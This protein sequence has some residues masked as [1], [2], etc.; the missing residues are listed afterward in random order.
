M[1]TTAI[2]AL[3]ALT[4]LGPSANAA[5]VL[6]MSDLETSLPPEFSG[7]GAIEDVQSF[8]LVTFGTKF[9]R[10]DAAGNPAAATILTVTNLA[11]HTTLSLS[12][13]LAVIDSWDGP[14]NDAFTVTLDGNPVFTSGYSNFDLD[15]PHSG[16]LLYSGVFGFSST[17]T[18]T[19]SAYSIRLPGL[20]HTASTATFAFFAGGPDWSGG[21]DESWAI[22]NLALESDAVPEPRS[23]FLLTPGAIA[24]VALARRK[25][26]S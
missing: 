25:R 19:D 10:N 12:F 24:L 1:R 4:I 20:A 14:G 17:F 3:A 8:P 22:D 15:Q 5:T 11:P 13:V 2:A 23:L 6:V 21:T 9:L 16:T 18:E 26:R 7:A